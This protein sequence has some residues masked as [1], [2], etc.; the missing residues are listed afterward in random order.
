MFLSQRTYPEIHFAVI[1]LSTKYNKAT[2][3]DMK[4]AVRVADY[5]NG[6]KDH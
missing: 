3:E 4:K 6:C 1:K 5:I 2:K